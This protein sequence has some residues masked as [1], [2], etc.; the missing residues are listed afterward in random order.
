MVNSSI[1]VRLVTGHRFGRSLF[2]DQ[3][4]SLR[5]DSRCGGRT[6]FDRRIAGHA[7]DRGGETSI[8]GGDKPA[9]PEAGRAPCS[10]ERH[11]GVWY[12]L[13]M[14][15]HKGRLRQRYA[16]RF[17]QLG[18]TESG[19]ARGRRLPRLEPLIRQPARS[20]TLLYS[21]HLLFPSQQF[22]LR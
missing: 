1:I 5:R 21:H 6:R 20:V 15:V 8:D 19:L 11:V 14:G 16:A 3:R 13:V 17:G 7:G 18:G 2:A 22:E 4:A 12:R 10:N 9:C